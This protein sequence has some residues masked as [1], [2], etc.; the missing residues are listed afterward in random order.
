MCTWR[1]WRRWLRHTELR[2]LAELIGP[3]GMKYLSERLM[4][5]VSSQVEAL[6][7][8]SRHHDIITIM[9]D[10]GLTCG[11]L[12]LC[13][14]SK[15]LSV[16]NFRYTFLVNL[17]HGFGVW[18][19]SNLYVCCLNAPQCL[20]CFAC[21]C[22]K[23]SFKTKA[24]WWSYG[25]ALIGRSAWKNWPRRCKVRY[26]MVTLHAATCIDGCTCYYMHARTPF[27]WSLINSHIWDWLVDWHVVLVHVDADNVLQRITIIGVLLSFRGLAQE[28]LCDVSTPL[29][30]SLCFLIVS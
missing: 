17:K 4:W 16:W 6:K 13:F 11:S 19:I 21:C 10:D 28:A 22:R 20:F 25:R 12:N 24:C 8:R 27:C 9:N 1:N 29:L 15:R 5:H 2:A 26:V 30:V 3:Y 23:W 14:F 7:V 18:Y